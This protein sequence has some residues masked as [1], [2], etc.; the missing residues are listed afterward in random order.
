MANTL[1]VLQTYIQMSFYL[2]HFSSFLM[3][4]ILKGQNTRVINEAII[5]IV[6]PLT[7]WCA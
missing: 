3:K 7:G 1:N 4:F 5:A 2:F 6:T